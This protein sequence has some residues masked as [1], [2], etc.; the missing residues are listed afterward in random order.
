MSDTPTEHPDPEIT[1]LLQAWNGGDPSALGDLLPLIVQ[2]LR[3]MAAFHLARENPGHTLQATA[4]VNEVYLK[5][6]KRQ[7]VDWQDRDHFFATLGTLMRRIL[8]DHARHKRTAKKGG[9]SAHVSFEEVLGNGTLS[10]V[11]AQAESIIAVDLALK[12]LA[13]LDP[14]MVKVVE[15]RF[16]AGLTIDET[17]DALDISPMSVKRDWRG[18]RLWLIKELKAEEGSSTNGDSSEDT[19]DS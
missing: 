3:K 15:L 6:A 17:A 2:D 11:D 16:F 14:R 9:G 10:D 12:S 7:S 4:L 19:G 13:T 8:V 1:Q 5:L 18:A